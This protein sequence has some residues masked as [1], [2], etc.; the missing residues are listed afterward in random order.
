MAA[1][2]GRN[3]IF[4]YPANSES[5]EKSDGHKSPENPEVIEHAQEP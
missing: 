5:R 1:L 4:K 3:V 2:P